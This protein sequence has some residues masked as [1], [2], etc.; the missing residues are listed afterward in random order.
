MVGLGDKESS[1]SL[2]LK[3]NGMDLVL[4]KSSDP[5]TLIGLEPAELKK[6]LN[7]KNVLDL[8]NF[9][10]GQYVKLGLMD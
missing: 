6:L 10:K 5:N 2:G 4:L 7:V 9:E 3:V 1:D 8:Q